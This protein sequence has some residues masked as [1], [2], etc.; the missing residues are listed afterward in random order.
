MRSYKDAV[1]IADNASKSVLDDELRWVAFRCVLQHLL[2]P[3]SEIKKPKT[4]K[5]KAKKRE[6]RIRSVTGWA[7]I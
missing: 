3:K 2:S 1:K 6:K 5:P 4:K 7:E